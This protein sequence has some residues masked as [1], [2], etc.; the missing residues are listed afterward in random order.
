MLD[1]TFTDRLTPRLQA[2]LK[3]AVDFT[4]AMRTIADI[5]RTQ[6]LERFE[7]ET[8]PDGVRW[9]PSQRALEDGGLT[10]TDTGHLKQSITAA[11]T[12]TSAV[13]GTNLLYAAIH[14]FG[15]S[16][17]AKTQKALKTPFGPRGAVNMPAR[18]FVGFGP[19]DIAEIEA[20]LDNHLAR[21]LA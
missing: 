9:K 6:T 14:Q 13:V 18:P 2:G 10:L 16:I 7:A 1:F 5:M 19:A 20:V 11:S 15:G 4:P 3:A 12:A 21:A 8:G 17:R